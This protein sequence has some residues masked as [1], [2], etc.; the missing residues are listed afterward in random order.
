MTLL[1]THQ[2]EQRKPVLLQKQRSVIL[3]FKLMQLI[4]SSM[5]CQSYLRLLYMQPIVEIS[6]NFIPVDDYIIGTITNQYTRNGL[7]FA[8]IK[9]IYSWLI[10]L[11]HEG[12][13]NFESNEFYSTGLNYL[14]CFTYHCRK[15]RQGWL[16]YK[17]HNN[18]SKSNDA[19]SLQL[20]HLDIF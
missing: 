2:Y 8:S 7:G 4:L 9:I 18:R 13:Q 3:W 12:I 6:F 16:W 10:E 17:V 19:L 11:K 20:W 14:L 15:D 5:N 1:F